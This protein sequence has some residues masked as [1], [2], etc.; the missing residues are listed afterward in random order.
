MN[1]KEQ[2]LYQSNIPV[3]NYVVYSIFLNNKCV[4]RGNYLLHD[5]TFNFLFYCD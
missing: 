2:V 4:A 5:L 1:I 3:S